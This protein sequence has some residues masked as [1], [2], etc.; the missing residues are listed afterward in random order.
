[1]IS[2]PLENNLVQTNQILNFHSA[3]NGNVIGLSAL[4]CN[5]SNVTTAIVCS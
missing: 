3:S 4:P 1:M 5:V 2:R